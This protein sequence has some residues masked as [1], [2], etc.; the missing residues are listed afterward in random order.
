VFRIAP[1]ASGA[2]ELALVPILRA[3]LG[4]VEG[5][6]SSSPSGS[7]TSGCIAT[8]RRCNPSV[9]FKIPWRATAF[10]L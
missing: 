10:F 6:S 7:G 8:T 5:I 1:E 2:A 3:G 4:M 9:C